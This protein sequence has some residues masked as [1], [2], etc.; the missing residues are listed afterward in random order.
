VKI[1]WRARALST[2]Y[3]PNRTTSR[4]ARPPRRGVNR[5]SES[6]RQSVSWDARQWWGQ[7]T[8]RPAG[9]P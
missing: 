7:S 6:N 9:S 3:S 1:L 2:H 5:M 4:P 8:H